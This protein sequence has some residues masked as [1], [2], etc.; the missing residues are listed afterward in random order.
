MEGTL[1]VTPE[2]LKTTA[3]TFQAK[4]SAVKAQHDAMLSKVRALST[5]FTGNAAE[6]YSAKFAALQTGMDK[7][8]SM[9][10][11]HVRDL[12]EMADQYSQAEAT[13]VSAAENLPASNL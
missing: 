7:I 11:E 1:L 4:G 6:A 5:T 8:Y 2:T 9:I 3:S 12:N 13:A 10:S